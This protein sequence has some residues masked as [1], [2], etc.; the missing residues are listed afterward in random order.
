MNI[1][2]LLW[3]IAGLSFLAVSGI[4]TIF[5]LLYKVTKEIK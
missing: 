4:F 2:A 5:V 3:I 1:T